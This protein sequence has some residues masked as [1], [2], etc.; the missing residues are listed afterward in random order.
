MIIE[1]KTRGF[2]CTTSH[3]K[4]CERSVL[5]QIDYI[6]SKG[7]IKSAKNVLVIGASTGFGLASR[8]TSAFGSNS[9]TIGV[10]FLKSHL[11]QGKQ[12]HLDGT[13]QPLLKLQPTTKEFTPK[14]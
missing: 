5:K 14:A 3:P 7:A 6:K 11:L 12:L 2:I 10:F 1:P 8:I 13:I 9:A 4:G